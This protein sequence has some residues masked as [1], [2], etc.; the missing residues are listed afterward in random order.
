LGITPEVQPSTSCCYRMFISSVKLKELGLGHMVKDRALQFW[1]GI[2]IDRVIA[3]SARDG[4]I[5]CCYAFY[6]AEKN[7]LREDGWH[8]EAS[9]QQLLDT[10]PEVDPDVRKLFLH[11]EDIKQWRLFIHPEYP[12]WQIGKACILGDAAHPMMPD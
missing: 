7:D 4:D 11:A 2:G 10:F 3:G 1:G 9:P 6:A 12:Y 5:L 8:L